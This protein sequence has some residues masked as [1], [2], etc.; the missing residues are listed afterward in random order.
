MSENK[1]KEFNLTIAY[2]ALRKCSVVDGLAAIQC[3]FD[4]LPLALRADLIELIPIYLDKYLDNKNS[5]G[6]NDVK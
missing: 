6:L 4:C 2:E 5:R 3:W 1:E